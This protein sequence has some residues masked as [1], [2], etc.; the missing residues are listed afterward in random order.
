MRIE[1][2]I[3]CLDREGDLL[4]WAAGRAGLDAPAPTCPGWRIRDLLAH[5]GF[6]HRW[7]AGYIA[8][9]RTEASAEPGD[10]EILR[11]APADESLVG[12]FREGHASLVSVLA[13][14]APAARCWT[15]LPAP[16]PP[17]SWA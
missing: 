8:E 4:A 3:A 9:E 17:A 14:A 2:H 16:S 7:A 6:V 10:E 13:A 1:D 5:L 12:W 11:L 15:L